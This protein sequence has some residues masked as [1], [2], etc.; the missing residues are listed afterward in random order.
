MFVL[1][2]LWCWGVVATIPVLGAE[3]RLG[4]RGF[5]LGLGLLL[6]A[7]SALLIVS[8][9]L[10]PKDEAVQELKADG[11]PLGVELWAVLSTLG[12]LGGYTVLLWAAGFLVAT[13]I[14]VAAGL[15][16]I[17]G[18]RN[19]LFVALMSF[20]TALVV[21]VTFNKILGVY[22]PHGRWIDI[23]F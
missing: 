5:P 20:G 3:G 2:A 14:I 11:P 21:F 10:S 8:S 18:K 19:W 4:P 12:F 1:A 7:F 9:F 23:W 22:L 13:V 6:A 16:L 17:L 15:V